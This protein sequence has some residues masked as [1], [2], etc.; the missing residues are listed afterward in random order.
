MTNDDFIFY[1]RPTRVVLNG[2]DDANILRGDNRDNRLNGRGGNDVLYGLDGED[3]LTGGDGEDT[4]HGGRGSDTFFITYEVDDNNDLIVDTVHG[5]GD[6]DGDG[7]IGTDESGADADPDSKDTISYEDWNK[8][9]N[10]GVVL[11]LRTNPSNDTTDVDGIEN[12]IGSPH[13]DTLTG[14]DRDNVIEGGDDDDVL[15]GGNHGTGG[16]TVS[17]R[18]SDEAVI[19]SL[20]PNFNLQGGH[21]DDD[22][23]SNFENIIGSRHAD[24]LTGDSG[25]NIIEG[26]GSGDTLDGGGGTNTLSYASS[27]RGVTV[28][29][30]AVTETADFSGTDAAIIKESNRGDAEGDKVRAGTFD[31][32][33]GSGSTDVLTGNG[34]PNTLRGGR[35][36]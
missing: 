7:T 18:S 13:E 30:N 23:I 20:V 4:M 33:I 8:G 16:D 34:E 35:R 12:I 3:E 31:N 28:D 22:T 25:N 9:S 26:L 15:D 36:Q 2:N 5:E 19:V 21:A 1:D 17:Y 32:I 14:D 10:P 29:L 24:T 11:N 27:S 6:L